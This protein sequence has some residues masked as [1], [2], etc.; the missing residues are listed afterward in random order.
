MP[1]QLAD[2]QIRSVIESLHQQQ[3]RVTGLAVRAELRRLY[4]VPGGVDRIYRLLNELQP[5]A[6]IDSSRRL[7]EELAS[8]KNQLALAV[9]RAELAEH[10]E[11]AHQ[12]K[13][14]MEIDQ[15][16]QQL[17]A[18]Q[19]DSRK[20]GEAQNQ[21]LELRRELHRLTSGPM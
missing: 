16:R 3:Q 13:W 14:A 19:V 5:H 18:A 4:G 11:Q 9:Q 1:K 7:R 21:V 2:D 20:L 17:R 10:R 15:L 6:S 8:L 12:E